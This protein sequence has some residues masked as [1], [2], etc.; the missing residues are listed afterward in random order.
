MDEGGNVQRPTK[1]RDTHYEVPYVLFIHLSLVQVGGLSNSL[2]RFP[3]VGRRPVVSVVPRAERMD[4]KKED[5][6]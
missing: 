1:Q 5:L 3:F 6:V 4:V 2:N